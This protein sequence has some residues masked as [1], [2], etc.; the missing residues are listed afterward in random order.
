[1]GKSELTRPSFGAVMGTIGAVAG[2]AALIISLSSNADALSGRAVVRKGDIAPGAVTA[3]SLARGAVHPKALANGAVNAK[4]LANSSVNAKTLANDAVTSSALA[5]GSVTPNALAHDAV[6][7]NALA[8]D[9]VTAS[10]IAPGS[11]YGAALGAQTVH[12][13]PIADL[14][15]VAENGTWTASNTE[16]ATC[17]PGE[18]L[19]GGGLNFTNPGNREVA[20]LEALP[21]ISATTNG[22]SGRITSTSGG[23]AVAEVEAL[24]L[25]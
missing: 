8:D 18:R 15:A 3:R 10:A 16:V 2:L 24:C 7:P 6:T 19:L 4:A 14:D 12:M 17:A 22:V 1:M 13:V 23:S 5:K 11:V 21:F 9:S 25:K 20:F